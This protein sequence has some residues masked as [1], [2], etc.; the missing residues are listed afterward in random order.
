MQARGQPHEG[1]S[2]EIGPA[3]TAMTAIQI[4]P[5]RW[6]FSRRT[7]SHRGQHGFLAVPSR[8]STNASRQMELRPQTQQVNGTSSVLDSTPDTGRV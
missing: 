5:E 1:R 7:L 8:L 2:A 3:K 4:S 6:S